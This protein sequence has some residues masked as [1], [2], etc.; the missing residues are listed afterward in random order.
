[1]SNLPI[2]GSGV[3]NN[4]PVNAGFESSFGYH[5]NADGTVATT[6]TNSGGV[7]N[8][9][10]WLRNA[11]GALIIGAKVAGAMITESGVLTNTDGSAVATTAQTSPFRNSRGLLVNADGSMIVNNG[12]T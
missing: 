5:I 6:T 4:G 3:V 9:N 11:A 8:S 10:G 1:M 2:L 7:R 12:A